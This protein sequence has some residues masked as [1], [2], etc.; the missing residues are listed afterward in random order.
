M[1]PSEQGSFSKPV[2]KSTRSHMLESKLKIGSRSLGDLTLSLENSDSSRFNSDLI[3]M[4]DYPADK[5]AI[6]STAFLLFP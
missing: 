5:C 6:K 4:D 3:Q 2:K 1:K